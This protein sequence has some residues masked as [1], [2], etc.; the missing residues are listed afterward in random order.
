L[1]RG[2]HPIAASRLEAKAIAALEG[3]GAKQQ[4][5]FGKP[6]NISLVFC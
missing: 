3:S 2:L 5:L 4:T 1:R 6:Q